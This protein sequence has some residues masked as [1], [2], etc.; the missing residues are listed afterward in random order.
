ML[1][2]LLTLMINCLQCSSFV[3]CFGYKL[4]LNEV[5][6]MTWV[7]VSGRD[8]GELWRSLQ[9][10]TVEGLSRFRHLCGPTYRS[11][12]GK[13]HHVKL[14]QNNFSHKFS[15][16]WIRS[17]KKILDLV[18]VLLELWFISALFGFA[19]VQLKQVIPRTQ[20]EQM[21]YSLAAERR[22]MR[23]IHAEIINDLLSSCSSQTGERRHCSLTFSRCVCLLA[24]LWREVSGTLA[25]GNESWIRSWVLIKGVVRFVWCLFINTPP[26]L[27]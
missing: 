15:H 23:L 11:R 4:L 3:N 14:N 19:Q 6:L 26:T 22:R 5:R 10:Q 1:Q 18:Q 7:F 9:R 13:K 16:P 17:V 12:K 20:A 24:R 25:T 8:I 2:I 27:I 21:E